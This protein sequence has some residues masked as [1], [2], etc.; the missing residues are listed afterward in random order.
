MKRKLP[1]K[2]ALRELHKFVD[3]SFNRPLP[4]MSRK[5]QIEAAANQHGG[6]YKS[7]LREKINFVYGAEWADENPKIDYKEKLNI[8]VEA[9]KFIKKHLSSM[10]NYS[11]VQG[12]LHEVKETLEKIEEA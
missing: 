8:A 7:T 11:L 10:E 3:E 1:N 9:L 4:V 6:N 2:K 5:R 12:V